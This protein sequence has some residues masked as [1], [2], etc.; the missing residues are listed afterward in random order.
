MCCA[1]N[2]EKITMAREV[3]TERDRQKWRGKKLNTRI[4]SSLDECER[5]REGRDVELKTFMTT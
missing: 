5:E 3:E 2:E 1:N 4:K